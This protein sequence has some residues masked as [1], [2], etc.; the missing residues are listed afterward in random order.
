M[1]EE[2]TCDT[3]LARSTFTRSLIQTESVTRY[4]KV[5]SER[6]KPVNFLT[7]FRR[8]VVDVEDLNV[9]ID[10]GGQPRAASV[11]GRHDQRV[12]GLLLAVEAGNAPEDAVDATDAELAH[13]RVLKN[14]LHLRIL[15]DV[16]VKSSD[17]GDRGV[18]RGIFRHVEDRDGLEN[19]S[20]V[21][22]VVD[23]DLDDASRRQLLER[24]GVIC[25]RHLLKEN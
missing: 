13:L 17:G 22:D 10:L 19:G 18:G 6:G 21:V 3:L 14:V 25:H 15:S 1:T 20:L 16:P 24:V 4:F 11:H 7:E 23:G 8:I 5:N 2:V 12:L 9:D